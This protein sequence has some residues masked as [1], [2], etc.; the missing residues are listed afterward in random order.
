MFG[1]LMYCVLGRLDGA[2]RY[3]GIEALTESIL[4]TNC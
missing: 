1:W 2:E 4:Y 3:D